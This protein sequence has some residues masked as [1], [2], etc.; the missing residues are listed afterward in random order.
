MTTTFSS[1][2]TIFWFNVK[3]S[4]YVLQ[5]TAIIIAIPL[6]T[7]LQMTHADN[8]TNASSIKSNT[9][10][11]IAADNLQQPANTVSL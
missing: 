8:T 4:F 10:N 2:A 5:L 11:T 1:T 6:L 9:V 3:R 7:Y